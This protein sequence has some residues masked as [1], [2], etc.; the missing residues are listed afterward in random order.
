[1]PIDKRLLFVPAAILGAGLILSLSIYFARA[2]GIVEPSRHNPEAIR[3]VNPETDHIIGNPDASVVIVEYSDIDCK[4]CKSFQQTMAQ[5]MTEYGATGNVAWVYRHLPLVDVHPDAALHAEAAECAGSLGGEQAFWR[6]IDLV[7]A[8]AP[9][10]NQFEPDGYPSIAAQLG[11]SQDAFTACMVGQ[12]FE[13]GVNDD[14]I[15]AIEAGAEGAPYVVLLVEG[16][17]AEALE[18]ALPYAT[19]KRIIDN[20]LKN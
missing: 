7:Q 20:A 16:R 3:A 19:I 14:F 6:F 11:L 18:G 4:Y 5:I 1:M 9:G 10:V 13:G 12:K 15:N 17:Q 2:S 8:T